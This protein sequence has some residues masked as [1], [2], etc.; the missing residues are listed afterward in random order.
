MYSICFIGRTYNVESV[1]LK[2]EVLKPHCKVFY[3][4][5]KVLDLQ[6]YMIIEVGM[7]AKK[8]EAQSPAQR[9]VSHRIRLCNSEFNL[10]GSRRPLKTEA[11]L[12]N[13]FQCLSVLIMKN[14]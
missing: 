2:A 11:S 7:D 5:C 12:G 3:I 14:M 8:P 4:Q 9:R 13:L 1:Y 6:D 10:A